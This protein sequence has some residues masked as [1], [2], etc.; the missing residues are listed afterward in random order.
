MARPEGFEPPTTWFEVIRS[1]LRIL[2]YLQY[3]SDLFCPIKLVYLDLIGAIWGCLQRSIGQLFL[4][5]SLRPN[6]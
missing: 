5:V 3:L 2:L 1:E 6:L 4:D